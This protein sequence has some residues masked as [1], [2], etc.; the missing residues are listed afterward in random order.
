MDGVEEG[1]EGGDVITMDGRHGVVRLAEPAED[2]AGGWR[3]RGMCG[4]LWRLRFLVRTFVSNSV[5]YALDM[6]VLV[7][8]PMAQPSVWA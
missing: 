7:E 6:G 4:G 8:S 3:C 2:D 1:V 5:M